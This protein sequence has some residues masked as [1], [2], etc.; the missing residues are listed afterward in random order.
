MSWLV[1]YLQFDSSTYTENPAP[2][3]HFRGVDGSAPADV[4]EAPTAEE[5]LASRNESGL[6]LS[7]L[8]DRVTEANDKGVVIRPNGSRREIAGP[9]ALGYSMAAWSPDGSQF[10]AMSDGGRGFAMTAFSIDGA[11]PQIIVRFAQVNGLRSWPGR[12]DVSWQAA[13]TSNPPPTSVAPTSASPGPIR[14]APIPTSDVVEVVR[15]WPGTGRNS[16]GV[17][18]WDGFSCSSDF[19]VLGFMHNGYGTGDVEIRIAVDPSGPDTDDGTTS[20]SV[21]GHDGTYRRIDAQQEEWIV[22]IEGTTIAIHLKA[23]P[24]ASLTDLA[25]AHAIIEL[26]RTVP[27]D[28]NFGFRLVLPLTSNDWDS[29]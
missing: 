5:L 12:G 19:C 20:V 23:R 16:A 2:S 3:L 6:L 1:V 8:G 27:Q 22:D 7:S 25:E 9:V 13:S 21:A 17:Y 15:G 24:D 29:G 4:A 10:L 14:T 18:S 11:A 26:M 28:N